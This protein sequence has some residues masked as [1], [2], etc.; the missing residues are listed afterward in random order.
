VDLA[1]PA[2]IVIAEAAGSST[3]RSTVVSTSNVAVNLNV[4]VK[5]CVIV[6]VTTRRQP[7][8]STFERADAR[9]PAPA[10]KRRNTT[11]TNCD[12]AM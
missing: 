3:S 10:D 4:R 9:R 7:S 2:S 8:I 11:A 1:L 12:W 6:K 5:V